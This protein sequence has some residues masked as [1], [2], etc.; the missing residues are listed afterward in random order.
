M[1]G[2]LAGLQEMKNAEETIQRRFRAVPNGWRDIRML[3]AVT[4]NLIDKLLLTYPVEKLTSM[5]RMM[6]HMKYRLHCG[7]SASKLNEDECIISEKELDTL[8]VFAHEQCKLC[9]EQNCNRCALG[10]VLDGI[11][12][13]DRE[14][15]SWA[16]IDIGGDN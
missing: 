6:P 11:L 13:N 2:L 10:K 16:S 5:K 9:V 14:G 7:V 4:S 15:R 1:F 8:S 3:E 12:C